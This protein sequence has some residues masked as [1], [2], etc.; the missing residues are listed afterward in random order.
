VQQTRKTVWIALAANLVIMLAKLVA[1]LVSGSSAMLAETAHSVADTANQG[2]LLLSLKLGERQ[3][4]QEH[5]FG[6]GTERFFWAF[7]AA[8]VIFLSGA[9]FSIGEGVL[10]L[11]GVTTGEGS[12]IVAVVVLAVSFVAEGTSLVRASRQTQAEARDA[13]ASWRDFVR[14]SSDPTA[15]FVVF[16]DAAA[17]AGIVIAFV[18]VVAS[19]V[20]GS[21]LWD[22]GA[23]VA[24]GILLAYVALRLGRDMRGLLL[25]RGAPADKRERIRKII[26]THP[27]VD[28]VVDLRTLYLGPRSL[29]V[30]SRV[31]LDDGVNGAAAERL[32]TEIARDLREQESDVSEV[33]L[34]PTRAGEADP[35]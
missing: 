25:G 33:F 6:H 1:G 29:L 32:A 10:R 24:I 7:L 2:M 30:A 31:D 3:P 17:V 9:V 23:S 14:E 8:V 28:E 5:P 35:A 11:L 22:G 12:W 13:G 34:D 15:K 19:A 20:T 27:G 16:E 4:D 21:E 18:G 26:A